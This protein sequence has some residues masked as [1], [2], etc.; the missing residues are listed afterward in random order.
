[1]NRSGCWIDTNFYRYFDA[2]AAGILGS[3]VTSVIKSEFKY[4]ALPRISRVDRGTSYTV[5]DCVVTGHLPDK[6]DFHLESDA[7]VDVDNIGT[8]LPAFK[9]RIYLTAIIRGI[10]IKA[11]DIRFTYRSRAISEAGVMKKVKIPHADLTIDFVLLPAT[12]MAGMTQTGMRYEFVRT[13]SHFNIAD[14]LIRYKKDTL[15]HSF[16]TPTVTKLFKGTITD[17]FETGI[18][19]ALDKSLQVLGQNVT[20]LLN[21]APNPLSISTITSF[22]PTII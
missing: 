15:S 14:I 10:A 19:Q 17:R 22:M 7:R 5:E 16:L 8:S 3:S 21:Q 13:K 9:T 11:K 20:R 4:L 2:E 1:M 12:S 6:I 18:E